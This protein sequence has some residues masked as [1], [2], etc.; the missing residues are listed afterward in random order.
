MWGAISGGIQAVAKFLGIIE[1]WNRRKE[2]QEAE[3]VGAAKQRHADDQE[4][5]K[6]KDEQLEAAA[7]RRPGDARRRLR[8]KDF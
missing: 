1:W 2:R 7:N 5:I 4:A 3:A 6:R 8:R